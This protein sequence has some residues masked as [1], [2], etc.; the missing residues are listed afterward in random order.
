MAKALRGC[1]L[2]IGKEPGSA[3]RIRQN[4]GPSDPSRRWR[5]FGSRNTAK[6]YEAGVPQRTIVI[7]F[8]SVAAAI[9][10]HDSP[11]YQPQFR[12]IRM[13]EGVE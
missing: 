13:V 6:T 12:D 2:S 4:L 3:C 5:Y 7:E 1:D 8:D 11:A 9:A 10:A